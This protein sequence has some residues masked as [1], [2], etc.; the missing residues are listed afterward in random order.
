MTLS[1]IL[2]ALAA[3]FWPLRRITGKDGL[4]LPFLSVLFCCAGG[5]TALLPGGD[6][7]PAATGAA[8]VLL[9]ALLTPE[10]RGR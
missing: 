6:L 10:R 3:F 2:F 9:S 5:L 8:A 1:W 7:L 4:L